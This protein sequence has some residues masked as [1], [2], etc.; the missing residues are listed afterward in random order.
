MRPW[1][2]VIGDLNG[3][4]A[5]DLATADRDDGKVSVL[6]YSNSIGGFAAIKDVNV[7]SEPR[8]VDVG[9][10]DGDGD[11]DIVCMNSSGANASLIRHT[12]VGCCNALTGNVDCDPADGVDI[13]D[14]SRLIDFLYISFDPLCCESEANVDGQPGTDISDLSTLI[15]YLY[16][17]FT[18]PAACQ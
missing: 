7:G 13:S 6:L 18:P 1:S 5:L 10:L 3:D 4:G 2:L 17:S 12:Y 16:I 15:D 8:F 14:L 9:D 11:L